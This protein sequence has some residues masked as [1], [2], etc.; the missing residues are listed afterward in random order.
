MSEQSK[1]LTVALTIE[2]KST[3]YS[4]GDVEKEKEIFWTQLLVNG[5][6]TSIKEI[7]IE[8]PAGTDLTEL[9]IVY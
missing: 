7:S 5:E 2:P 1:K 3:V 4:Y 6:K 9:T 8:K